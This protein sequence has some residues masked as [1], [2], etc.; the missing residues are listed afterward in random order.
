MKKII[1]LLLP[2]FA[3][4]HFGLIIPSNSIVTEDKNIKITYGFAH[5][6]MQDF[7]VLEKPIQA[8]V[9]KNGKVEDITK[10]LKKNGKT[11]SMDYT[12]EE[13]AVYQFFLKPQPYFEPSEEKFIQHLSKTIVD[14]YGAGEGW[15]T[16]I[17][18]K[19]EI[20]PLT[21][22]YGLYKGNIFSGKVLQNGKIAKNVYVEIELFNDKNHKAKSEFHST[23]VVKTDDNGIFHFAFPAFGWWAFSALLEDDITIKKDNINYPVELGA[24]LWVFVDNWE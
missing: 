14:G 13:P 5:P 11:W 9:F 22:P 21:R 3:Y 19:A 24:V 6:Y 7:M 10:N 2:L 4:A 23:Q 16:P 20:I 15:D 8:A 17:G 18:L 12:I 1:I